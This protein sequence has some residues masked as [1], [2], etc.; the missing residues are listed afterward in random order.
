M[1]VVYS[2][3]PELVDDILKDNRFPSHNYLSWALHGAS[4]DKLLLSFV[5]KYEIENLLCEWIHICL[6]ENLCPS[7][8]NQWMDFIH[9]T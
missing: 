8:P 7:C 2:R 1:L 4:S 9:R 3:A 5:A 6:L